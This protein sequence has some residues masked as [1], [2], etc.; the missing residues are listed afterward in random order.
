MFLSRPFFYVRE[1]EVSDFRK[2]VRCVCVC[3]ACGLD[4]TLH[5][6]FGG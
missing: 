6:E 5:S 2:C 4:F 1:N 3:V